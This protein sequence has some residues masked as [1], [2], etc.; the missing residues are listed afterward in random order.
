MLPLGC[1][2]WNDNILSGHREDKS[3]L[4][5]MMSQAAG[6]APKLSRKTLGNS[7][8]HAWSSG[9]FIVA[10]H[11]GCQNVLMLW[12]DCG[13]RCRHCVTVSRAYTC[14]WYRVRFLMNTCR[15]LFLLC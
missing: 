13:C 5:M 14:N 2:A 1:W 3:V 8:A 6:W 7:W 12:G 10:R 4:A 9:V 11:K 15:F